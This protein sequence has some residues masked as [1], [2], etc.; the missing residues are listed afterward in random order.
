[1]I[2]IDRFKEKKDQSNTLSFSGMRCPVYI[3]F[4]AVGKGVIMRFVLG[5]IFV[6]FRAGDVD[7]HDAFVFELDAEARD[8]H[9]KFGQ[10]HDATQ[11]SADFDRA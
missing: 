10:G 2:K 6:I 8:V 4:F 5:R 1:M 7:A 11:Y 9:R 3:M